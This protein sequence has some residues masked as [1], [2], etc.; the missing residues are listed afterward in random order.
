MSHEPAEPAGQLTS[1]PVIGFPNFERI[2][3]T[4]GHDIGGYKIIHLDRNITLSEV[5]KSENR[6]YTSC[7]GQ[8]G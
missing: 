2:N 1:G 7:T 4:F 8:Y 6:Q 5:L 3:F